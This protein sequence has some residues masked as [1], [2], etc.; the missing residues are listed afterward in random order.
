MSPRA[1]NRLRNLTR[2]NHWGMTQKH[3]KPP[4]TQVGNYT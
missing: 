4:T 1:Y 3:G 2:V